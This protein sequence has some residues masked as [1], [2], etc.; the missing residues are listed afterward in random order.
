MTVEPAL[1]VTDLSV[2]PM[3]G[4]A[5]HHPDSVEV[6]A[7]GIAGD[8][9]LFLL[10]DSGDIASITDHG[11]LAHYRAE[12]DAASGALTV[13]GPDGAVRSDVAEQGEPVDVDFYGLRTVAATR[14]PSWDAFFSE[15]VGAPVRLVRGVTLGFDVSG[16]T[17][18]GT[19]STAELASRNDLESVDGRRFRMNVGFSG[20]APHVEDTWDGRTLAIGEA[21]VRV[22][23]PVK[24]CAAT[25]RN[26]DTG[27][28]DLQTLR[29]IGAYR[30]RQE[31]PEFGPG[32][33]FGVYAETLTP[34]RVAVGDELR[35]LD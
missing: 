9:E 24:R 4:L 33:Y 21:V 15:I 35:L 22:G 5:L 13:H 10:E 28:V 14:A 3:K 30:G 8:R 17:L 32:F 25:T 19:A 6:T 34:G 31:T 26:P 16:L 20:G 2:T 12:F 11:P 23:G 29:M 1:R 27:V 7:H 18:L